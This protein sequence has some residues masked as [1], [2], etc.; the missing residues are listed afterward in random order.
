MFFRETDLKYGC[1]KSPYMYSTFKFSNL[2]PL[3]AIFFA[4]KG[5]IVS[6]NMGD[7]V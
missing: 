3:A 6:K 5:L 4:A 1:L 7:D 2:K